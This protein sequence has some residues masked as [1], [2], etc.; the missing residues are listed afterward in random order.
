MTSRYF[1]S[2]REIHVP[3]PL[4]DQKIF[5]DLVGGGVDDCDT[6]GRTERDERGLVVLGDADADGLDRFA[7]QARNIEGDLAGHLALDRD[8]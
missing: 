6:V 5:D 3:D 2:G 8:R 4:A 1:S 7:A